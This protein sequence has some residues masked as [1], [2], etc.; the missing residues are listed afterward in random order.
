MATPNYTLGRGK[1]YFARFATGQTPGPFRYMGNSPEFSLTI[2]SETLDHYSSDEG[3]REKDDSV[4]LE[5][6]RTGTLVCD[7]IQAENVALFFFGTTSVLTTSAAT[8]ETEDL[9]AV[10]PG[11]FYQIGLTEANKVGLRGLANVSVESNPSGTTYTAGTDYKIDTA[12]GMLEIVE[13]GG[14]SSGDDITVTYDV[15]ATTQEQIL[16]GSTPVEGALRF[17]ADN[18]RGENRDIFLP[19]CKITPNGDFALKGDDW[20]QLSFSLE[21]LKPSTGEAIY[22]NGRP[23]AGS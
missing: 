8:A 16:S 11:M 14:I 5:V 13:G 1:V 19:Y 7:D 22:I 12:T 23:V 3:I 17:V 2:E 9:D 15:T 18:P 4:P 20:Q 21:A 10:E 6:N